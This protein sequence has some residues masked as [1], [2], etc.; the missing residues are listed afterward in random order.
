MRWWEKRM[1]FYGYGGDIQYQQMTLVRC[2]RESSH[3]TSPTTPAR[4]TNI[5]VLRY[6]AGDRCSSRTLYMRSVQQPFQIRLCIIIIVVHFYPRFTFLLS[7]LNSNNNIAHHHK[8]NAHRRH[9]PRG[10]VPRRRQDSP[11][12]ARSSKSQKATGTGANT[13]TT[14]PISTIA[15]TYAPPPPSPSPLFPRLWSVGTPSIRILTLPITTQ[16][17][18]P[19]LPPRSLHH[20]TLPL[21]RRQAPQ[22]R[23]ACCSPFQCRA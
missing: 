15:A 21:H 2:L 11:E 23:R 5:R 14:H 20:P 16:R 13:T 6:H 3:P 12:M 22:C 7:V 10:Q 4:P 1:L 18:R 17:I 9:G 19:R 8:T